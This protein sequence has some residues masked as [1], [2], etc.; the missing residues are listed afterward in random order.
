MLAVLG[1]VEQ[2]VN[3]VQGVPEPARLLLLGLGLIWSGAAL[4][5]GLRLDHAV[6]SKPFAFEEAIAMKPADSRLGEEETRRQFVD[7]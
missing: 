5:R 4:R 1:F 2:S 7:C 6:E 3:F